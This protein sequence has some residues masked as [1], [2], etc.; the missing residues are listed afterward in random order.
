MCKILKELFSA[1]VVGAFDQFLDEGNVRFASFK[2]STAAQQQRL[3]DA[4]LEMPV[5]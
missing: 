1:V 2:S 5:G 4:I 3:I